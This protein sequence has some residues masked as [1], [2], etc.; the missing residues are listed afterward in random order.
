M[1]VVVDEPGRVRR[2]A[3]AEK[4]APSGSAAARGSFQRDV[5]VQL[6]LPQ[7]LLDL[8]QVDDAGEVDLAV[9]GDLR[10][11]AEDRART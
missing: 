2:R 7:H 5:A 6:P 11:R 3:L 4:G 1:H 9:G 10:E 8:R